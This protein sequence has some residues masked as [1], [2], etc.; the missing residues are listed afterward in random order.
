MTLLD[1]LPVS[2][3]I[4]DVRCHFFP[5]LLRRSGWSQTSPILH[6]RP[7]CDCRFPLKQA[8]TR[9]HQP[10]LHSSI[11]YPTSVTNPPIE[12]AKCRFFHC[13]R[14]LILATNLGDDSPYRP[15]MKCPGL[16]GNP[17]SGPRSRKRP[18]CRLTTSHAP[19]SCGARS[20]HN[21]DQ[22]TPE[23]AALV[24]SGL[25]WT[26]ASAPLAGAPRAGKRAA[27]GYWAPTAGRSRLRGIA[28]AR[29]CRHNIA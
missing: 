10:H 2:A 24:R 8:R 19:T 25:R 3:S 14:K 9:R 4:D 23:P 13:E 22:H 12:R 28:S 6:G 7:R 5:E 20:S 21:R 15:G 29:C 1:S 17:A 26:P 16:I 27:C 18:A 11:G